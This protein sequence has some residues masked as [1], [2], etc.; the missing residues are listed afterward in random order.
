MPVSVEKLKELFDYDA[1]SGELVWKQRDRAKFTSARIWNS[2]NTRY[3]GKKAGT[4][5]SYGYIQ[6]GMAG[7]L[8]LVHRCVW[9]IVTGKFPENEIDHIDGNRSNNRIANLR[10]ATHAQNSKNQ[11][12]RRNNASGYKGISLH[13][14]TGKYRAQIG[15]IHLGTFTS[16]QEAHAAY[17]EAANKLHGEFA[18]HGNTIAQIGRQQEAF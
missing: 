18:N 2:W 1:D 15:R 3:A 16:P 17:C 13:K 6:V 14:K 8:H 5:D 10:E 9:A 11:G 12:V 4:S 7:R